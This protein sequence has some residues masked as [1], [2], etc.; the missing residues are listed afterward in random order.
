MA[1]RKN[2]VIFYSDQQR[3]DSLGCMGNA[4]ARTP[5]LDALARRGVLY[6]RHHAT[7]PVCMPSRASFHTGR[8]PQA[9][10]VIDNGIFLP[11]DQVTLAETFRRAGY[12]TVS[13]GKLHFQTFARYE[14]DQS[15]ESL[16]RWGRGE[17]DGWNGPYYGFEEVGLTVAHGEGCGGHYGRWRERNFPGLKLGP[18]HAQGGEV[19]KQFACY[20]SNLPLEAHHSTWV[21]DRAVEFL[22]RRQPDDRPFLLHVSFPDPHHPF[23]PPAPY[24]SMFD[25]VEFP[26][27][28]AVPGENDTKPT[29]YRLTM[30]RQ[31]FPTDGGAKRHADLPGRAYQRVVAHTYGMVSLIDAS[32]GR[33]I[34]KLKE[35]GLLDRTV[36]VFSSD[37]GDFLGDHFLL[38]KGQL[39]CR[40]LL[41]IPLIVAD[42]D[43]RPGVCDA[44]CGNVDV[45]PT[46]L[47][48]CRLEIPETVQGMVLPSP[49]EPPRRDDA[50]EAGWSKA[51]Y[52]YHHFT[53]YT[54]DWRLSVFPNLREGEMYD[55]KADP[56]EH[57]NLYDDPAFRA[58]RQEL[59][60]S[61]LWAVGAA[62]PRKPPIVTMW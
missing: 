17:L 52:E 32:V 61:L 7:N 38:H 29:P 26:P 49:G 45:M 9:H 46:L 3:G 12:R 42:P 43:V 20:K 31:I 6:R 55:L 15:M 58:R 50:F 10:R 47:A 60:E 8:Y 56:H 16:D 59:T 44:V 41:H 53:L 54:E 37:H 21:A 14:G 23:T 19:F 5:N 36:I 24:H 11:A 2:V 25:D 27:P 4:L 48:S 34:A 1:Q 13:Y 18:D 39:P 28:H 57:R 35:R 33:V 30:T 51:S 22:D 40:S 62:E